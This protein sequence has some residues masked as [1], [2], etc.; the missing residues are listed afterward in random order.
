MSEA[1]FVAVS[2]RVAA[3]AVTSALFV[4]AIVVSQTV[5]C[6]VG[7]WFGKALRVV[8]H[9]VKSAI[10]SRVAVT[11]GLAISRVLADW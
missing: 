9:L 7:R 10:V 4:V 2:S 8:R 3:I 6:F 5:T 1:V 11:I